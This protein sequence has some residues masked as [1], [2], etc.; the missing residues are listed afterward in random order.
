MIWNGQILQIATRIGQNILE[1]QKI[2]SPSV[3]AI[4]ESVCFSG[5]FSH[6]KWIQILI[7]NSH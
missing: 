7:Y 4:D 2:Y 6:E 5:D 3:P 1:S